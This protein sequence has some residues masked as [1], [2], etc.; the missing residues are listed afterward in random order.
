MTLAMK[1]ACSAK[2]SQSLQEYIPWYWMISIAGRLVVL[3]L[4]DFLVFK[5]CSFSM[6]A[7]FNVRLAHVRSLNRNLRLQPVLNGCAKSPR[8]IYGSLLMILLLFSRSGIPSSHIDWLKTTLFYFVIPKST[9]VRLV[10][11]DFSAFEKVRASWVRHEELSILRIEHA[12]HTNEA[13]RHGRSD[14]KARQR[15]T[16][17]VDCFMDVNQKP[18]FICVLRASHPFYL[19]NLNPPGTP[20]WKN[21]LGSYFLLTA[22]NLALFCGPYPLIGSWP[23]YA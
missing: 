12:K 17:R 2:D 5:Y 23:L 16:L 19:N 8:R 14:T 4:L 11:V 13:I 18:F 10:A 6:Q 20:F 1:V 21:P 15:G 9:F 3:G 7:T 22:C